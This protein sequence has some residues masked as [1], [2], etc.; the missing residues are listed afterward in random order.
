M[1]ST[2]PQSVIA[3][4]EGTRSGVVQSDNKSSALIVDDVGMTDGQYIRYGLKGMT[5]HPP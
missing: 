1:G 5:L 3:M 4:G 2:R